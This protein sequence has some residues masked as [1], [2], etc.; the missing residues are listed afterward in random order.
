[1]AW[2]DLTGGESEYVETESGRKSDRPKLAAALSHAMAIGA[3][4]VFAKLDRLDP[5]RGSAAV[6]CR[7]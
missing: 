6:A 5:Q 7:Q 1:M 4:L 3:K 2:L